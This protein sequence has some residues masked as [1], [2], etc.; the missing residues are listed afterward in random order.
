MTPPRT[1]P[2]TTPIVRVKLT[3]PRP[4][5]RSC[6]PSLSFKRTVER[7]QVSAEDAPWRTLAVNMISIDLASISIS[8]EPPRIAIPKRNSHLR[9]ES[10][11]RPTHDHRA[12][13]KR[14]A[15][16]GEH[17]GDPVLDMPGWDS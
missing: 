10:F 15:I 16:D 4:F 8:V 13:E 11:N 14:C 7:T 6:V 9:F 1:G 3:H 12:N 17:G 5:P 2:I